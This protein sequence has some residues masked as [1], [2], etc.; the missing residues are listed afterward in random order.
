MYETMKAGKTPVI[1]SD[2]WVPPEGPCW[3]Q[4]SIRVSEREIPNLPKILSERE[5]DALKMGQL[6]R[7]T[8]EQW[9]SKETM[10]DTIVEACKSLRDNSDIAAGWRTLSILPH[11]IVSPKQIRRCVLSPI[12]QSLD[13]QLRTTKNS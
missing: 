10:F 2:H 13:M 12:K 3:D 9:F 6:A 4:F 11:I 8:W 5:K 1:I 7:S